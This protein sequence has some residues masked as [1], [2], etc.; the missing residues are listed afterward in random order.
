[1]AV[2]RFDEVFKKEIDAINSRREKQNP[3]R[4]CADFEFQEEPD[5]TPRTDPD[6]N[7]IIRPTKGS[8]LIGLA[9][10]GGGVRSAA[11]CLGALQALDEDGVLQRVD[12][13]STV[14]GG[15]YI[16]T[17][18]VAAMSTA[19][20]SK[21]PFPSKLEPEE[22]PAIRH[23]RD[24][25]NYLFPRGKFEV[26]NNLA[27]YLRGLV[28]NVFLLLPYLLFAASITLFVNPT[29]KD[30]ATPPTYWPFDLKAFGD[31][32]IVALLIVVLLGIWAIHRS[33]RLDRRDIGSVWTRSV[34]IS[35]TI[36][37]F[38]ATC[39]LQPLVLTAM[40]KADGSKVGSHLADQGGYL[41]TALLAYGSVV[42]FLSTFLANLLKQG[43]ESA[44]RQA[45]I[46][47]IGSKAV[48]YLAAGAVPLLLWIAY[49]YLS[50]YGIC[51]APAD[52][53][54]AHRHSSSGFSISR[55]RGLALS[56]VQAG[57]T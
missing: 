52:R 25:S 6:G 21:F 10:S 5:G 27:I 53:K 13:L 55:T 51:V 8:D 30:L 22:V 15:G 37:L 2:F 7:P 29:R 4:P 12:Y 14:S 41:V 39:E 16:G 11:F 36:L 3:G 24:H 38:V 23:I 46:L 54:I 48:M 1:M 26:F 9:L 17:S 33:F 18:M 19:Q 31:T 43:T 50:Y 57:F 49:L 34:G 35:L 40:F 42:S 28:A 44:S 45:R 20:D 47:R 32:V 56:A